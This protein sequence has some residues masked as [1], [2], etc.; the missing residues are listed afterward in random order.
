MFDVSLD[1]KR[2]AVFHPDCFETFAAVKCA[3]VHFLERTWK[4]YFFDSAFI[5]A[6]F[7]DELHATRNFD[8]FQILAAPEGVRLYSPQCGRKHDVL[9]RA[10]VEH[11][12]QVFFSINDFLCTELLQALVQLHV[13][14][15][16]AVLER[17]CADLPRARRE[18]YLFQSATGKA[19]YPNFLESVRKLDTL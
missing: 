14:Q 5:K 9:Y 8:A 6:I 7:S 13:L 15:L 19:S 17:L 10:A 16:L 3:S 4:S 1:I 11:F 2:A 12:S 18:N